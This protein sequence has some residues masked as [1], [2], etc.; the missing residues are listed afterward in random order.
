MIWN[1]FLRGKIQT[2][3]PT[4]LLTFGSLKAFFGKERPIDT[5]EGIQNGR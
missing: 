4:A 1:S 5:Y 3:F 2:Y